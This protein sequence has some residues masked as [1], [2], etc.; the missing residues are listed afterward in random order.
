MNKIVTLSLL[1][2]LSS[3]GYGQKYI[4]KNGNLKFEA[5]VSS[6]EEV[7]AINNKTMAIIEILKSDL[8][9]L[10]SIKDFH[11][12]S[13]LMEEHFNENYMESDKFPKATFI[14][15]IEGFD[16]SDITS[17][18]KSYKV[19][20]DLTLH[21]KTKKVNT[22]VVVSMSSGNI[23]LMGNFEIK[24]EDYGITIPKIMWNKIAEKVIIKYSLTL[25]KQ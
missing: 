1:M 23:S 19:S 6:F 12:K 21:G 14:G 7:K 16:I 10:S 15:K 3:Y 13:A 5:S 20:G 4:T 17:V 8:V 22:N 2:L 11:F 24:P 18:T 9:V 25:T